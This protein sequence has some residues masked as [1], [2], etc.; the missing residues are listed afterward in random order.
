VHGDLFLGIVGLEKEQLRDHQGGDAVF[1]RAGDEDDALLEQPRIDVVGALATIG[2]LDHHRDEIIHVG[3][4]RISHCS[5]LHRGGA[6][7]AANHRKTSTA[8]RRPAHAANWP[9]RRPQ[10]AAGSSSSRYSASLE[11]DFSATLTSS[12][13]KSTTFSS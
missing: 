8:A 5:V 4:D 13:R 12:S 1:H 6:S 3:I 2:L 9:G 10:A 7:A 11:T